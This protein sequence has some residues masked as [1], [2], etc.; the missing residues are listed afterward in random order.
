MA[1]ERQEVSGG[2]AAPMCANGCGFFG[3]AA[4]K[5]M[6]SKCYKEHVMKTAD[7]A[8]ATVAEKKAD[9]VAPAPAP[10]VEESGSSTET[11]EEHE[12]AAAAGASA[13]SAA[14][15]MCANGCSFFGSAATKNLCS[16]CYRDLLKAADAGP[17]V[18]EKIEAAPEHPAPEASAA[19]SSSA[20]PAAEAPAAKPA[21]SR[22]TS[23]NKKVGLL[24]FVCR[25]GG[26][27]CSLHRYTDEH[28]CGYD[29]KTA[30]REQI[31]KKNPVVVAPKINK[32]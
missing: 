24:G 10:A 6:C 8:A 12:A 25:C 15:V 32:I 5:N 16:S 28:A 14:P 7:T 27:F 18:A 31:A 30:G 19:A 23:C 9:D 29:F 21:P 13:D 11:T 22:C 4:T 20:A 1:A 26:T 2:G 3:S 17:A